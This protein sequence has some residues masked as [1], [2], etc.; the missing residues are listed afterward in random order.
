MCELIFRE[1]NDKYDDRVIEVGRWH[2]RDDGSRFFSSV[3]DICPVNKE[4]RTDCGD[5]YMDYSVS[6]DVFMKI[7]DKIKEIEGEKNE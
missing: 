1:N 2:E 7:A 4:V 5:S 3:L 6:F